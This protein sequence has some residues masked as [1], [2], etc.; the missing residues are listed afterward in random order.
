M[1]RFFGFLVSFLVVAATMSMSAE[2]DL[3][4][5]NVAKGPVATVL[6]FISLAAIILTTNLM[7]MILAKPLIED[8]GIKLLRL[9]FISI[10]VAFVACAAVAMVDGL[11]FL[12]L[13][14]VILGFVIFLVAIVALLAVSAIV[15]MDEYLRRLFLSFVGTTFAVVDIC[16]L[17]SLSLSSGTIMV[18]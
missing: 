12:P 8:K 4:L 9:F 10:S 16:L 18:H 15:R 1:K 17:I 2:Q 14:F 6:C 7:I 3:L 5:D 13:V 11:K